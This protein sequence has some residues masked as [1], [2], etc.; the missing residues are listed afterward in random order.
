LISTLPAALVAIVI[1]SPHERLLNFDLA[2]ICPASGSDLAMRNPH[3]DTAF[4][5]A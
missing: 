1:F 5:Q 4:T 2:S 3:C